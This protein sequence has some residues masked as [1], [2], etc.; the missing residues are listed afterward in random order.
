MKKS[1]KSQKKLA[2]KV[3]NQFC[4]MKNRFAME[5]AC[6]LFLIFRKSNEKKT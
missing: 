6:E 2:A 5:I 1:E 4:I 3:H